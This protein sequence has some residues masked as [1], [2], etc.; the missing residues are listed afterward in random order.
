MLYLAGIVGVNSLE[1]SLRNLLMFRHNEFQ[2]MYEK[3]IEVDCL[4]A[5]NF[6]ATMPSEHFANAYFTGYRYGD[7]CSTVAESF[8][9]WIIEDREL[10]ITSMIN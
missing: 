6:L 10:P 8:N 1:S 5:T 4:Q 7:L 3:F 9:S 2:K